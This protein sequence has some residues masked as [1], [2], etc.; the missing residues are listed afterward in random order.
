MK[1]IKTNLISNKFKHCI[2][3]WYKIAMHFSVTPLSWTNHARRM[4]FANFTKI[5]IYMYM[6]TYVHLLI[7]RYT[8]TYDLYVFM[9]ALK[10][11]KSMIIEK[12]LFF[13]TTLRLTIFVVFCFIE[14]NEGKKMKISS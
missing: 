9:D 2:N 8:F 1:L 7:Y 12:H 11:I 6:H 4:Q 10:I 3:E 5:C 13:C 14:N